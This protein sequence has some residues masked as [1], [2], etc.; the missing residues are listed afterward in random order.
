[1]WPNP[2]FLAD[3]V[4]FNEEI[5]N[6]KLNFLCSVTYQWKKTI[7][8]NCKLLFYFN[9]FYCAA[10]RNP[11]LTY[12]KNNCFFDKYVSSQCLTSKWIRGHLQI[13]PEAYKFYKKE[14][15]AQVFSCEFWEISEN[16]F[17]KNTSSGCFCRNTFS[18]VEVFSWKCSGKSYSI[19]R[20]SDQ[21]LLAVASRCLDPSSWM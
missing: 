3:L 17:L 14:T 15:L 11:S 5:L 16:T 6:G 20:T 7:F 10:F 12:L 4:T 8:W 2:Q 18:Y 9:K 1:M 13:L 19:E 21:L